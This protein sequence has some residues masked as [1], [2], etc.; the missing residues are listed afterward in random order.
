MKLTPLDLSQFD[1]IG[2]ATLA[3]DRLALLSIRE[4]LCSGLETYQYLEVGSAR[5]GSLQPHVIDRRCVKIFSI[6]PRPAEQPDERWK[7]PDRYTD[8][9]TQTMLDLL[10]AIPNADISK[11]QTFETSSWDLSTASIPASVNFAFVD[12]EH[13]NSAVVRD[14]EAVRRYLSPRSILAFHDCFIVPSAIL[15]IRRLLAR[16]GS[17]HQFLYF[18]ESYMVAIAFDP[19]NLVPALL[20]Y[21]WQ[22]RL[23]LHRWQA[24]RLKVRKHFPRSWEAVRHV[25]RFCTRSRSASRALF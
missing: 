17:R 9:S 19:D 3:S 24:L 15:D 10:S 8:N 4:A 5:G 12:G 25:K 6:D 7:E 18:P 13:T 22:K 2:S 16:E 1:S 23:P 21:G 20:E 11:I 14:F